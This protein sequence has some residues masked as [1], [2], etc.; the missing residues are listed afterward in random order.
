[1]IETIEIAPP[2]YWKDLLY[3][4]A[5]LYCFSLTIDG[6]V[7]WRLPRENES[8]DNCGYWC[9]CEDNPLKLPLQVHRGPNPPVNPATGDLWINH[10][11]EILCY[12]D[13]DY[14]NFG[15]VLVSNSVVQH[16]AGSPRL[17]IPVRDLKDD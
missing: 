14:G 2:E 1:M 4:D 6:K 16:F 17:T 11:H 13:P 7:G 12:S 9:L 3:E 5:K 10:K 8:I 15:W